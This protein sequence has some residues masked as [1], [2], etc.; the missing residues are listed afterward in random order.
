MKSAF[1]EIHADYLR[2][3]NDVIQLLPG[4]TAT[5]IPDAEIILIQIFD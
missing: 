2:L 4:G 1:L 3:E 5:T